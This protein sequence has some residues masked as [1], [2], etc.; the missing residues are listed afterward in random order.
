MVK[1]QRKRTM[2]SISQEYLDQIHSLLE[3]F[4]MRS[5]ISLRQIER[6]KALASWVQEQ[7]AEGNQVVIDPKLLNEAYKRHYKDM[8][9]EELRGLR[10]TIKNIE[11]L[12]RLK[13]KLLTA[14]EES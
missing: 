14:K 5:G 11:H 4:D 12:G 7:E 13:K 6:R 9:M 8:P 10:D 1:F 3:R 2:P